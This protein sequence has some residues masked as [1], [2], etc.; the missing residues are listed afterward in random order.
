MFSKLLEVKPWKL[1]WTV[2]NSH[3]YQ[4]HSKYAHKV[5]Q[6]KEFPTLEY[7]SH[8][9]VVIPP[10]QS[11]EDMLALKPRHFNVGNYYKLDLPKERF[12][13]IT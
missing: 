10:L 1:H 13:P 11:F 12:K 3:V 4:P 8:E 9:N 5:I 7:P 6:S 2:S